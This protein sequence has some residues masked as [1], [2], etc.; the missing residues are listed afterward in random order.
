MAI[1]DKLADLFNPGNKPASLPE[2]TSLQNL[3]YGISYEPMPDPA[4]PPQLNE[5]LED[6][7]YES[8]HRPSNALAKRL[9]KL[10]QQYPDVAILKNY[11]TTTYML[12]GQQRLSNQVL[13]QTLEQH[14]RYLLGLVN[15]ANQLLAKNDTAAVEDLFGGPPVD[16]AQ[17][18]P[19]RQEFHQ[20]EVGHFTFASFNYY[21]A[22]KDPDAALARLRLLRD[23]N[24]HNLEQLREMKGRLDA[25]RMAHNLAK[26]REDMDDAVTV[27][28][29][30][31]SEDQQTDEP[32]VFEHPDIQWLYEHG[33]DA[34]S[35]P[36][37][38]Q[39][40]DVLL[41][42][43]RASL[44]ADLSKVLLDII[45]RYEHFQAIEWN[46]SQNDFASH[47]LLLATELQAD[48]CLP[49]VLETLRQHT[50][51]RE[52]WWGDYLTEF[53]EPYFRQMLPNHA[54]TLKVFMQEPDIN[55]YSKVLVSEAY[56]Q[57]T[58]ANP[59][60]KPVAQLWYRDV[61]TYLLDHADDE[62]LLDTDLMAYLIG[63]ISELQLTDL[64]P[65]VRDAYR[66]N[67]VTE[68]IHGD[69]AYIEKKIVEPIY[70]TARNPLRS[71]ADQYEF[72]RDPTAYRQ[73]HLDPERK[74]R[75][76][77][78][79][80]GIM[81][82]ED[83]WAFLY[84]DDD[85]DDELPNG[86]LFPSRG[87]GLFSPVQPVIKQPAP[88]RNDKVTVRYTDGKLVNDVKY[89]KVE[90]DVTAGRCELL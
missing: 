18:Y 86:T 20:S 6:L 84:E 3:G 49:A 13:E 54:D 90:A 12:T 15:K 23:L 40:C 38:A 88:G 75:A 24:Y 31:R 60:L 79:I 70:P 51:F 85:E 25:V 26:M 82:Q 22:K 29:Y 27:E 17:F 77:E 50:E 14:P 80:K 56:M 57:Q 48:E 5:Q 28:G 36:L 74:E 7:Y 65:L 32:P 71:I 9:R 62:R 81:A 63:A 35:N 46:S 4:A 30:F 58:L 45:Y 83:E 39:K 78:F 59:A 64:L 19:E 10:V 89:K 61:L 52:F 66:R 73:V 16:I 41:A 69:L 33:L 55:T 68:A 87:S 2:R 1:L 8:R 34:T 47:A 53:Y 76:D 42:L 37:T 11:L 44:T 67:L 72:W 21:L 43:P